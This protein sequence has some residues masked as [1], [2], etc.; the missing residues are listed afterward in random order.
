MTSTGSKLGFRIKNLE[1]GPPMG[2]GGIA[3]C[4]A[5]LL[6]N[7]WMVDCKDM[8]VR[9]Q[10]NLGHNRAYGIMALYSLNSRQD[11]L[12]PPFRTRLGSFLTNK[13]HPF[14]KQA[15]GGGLRKGFQTLKCRTDKS[16]RL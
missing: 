1:K 2:G 15:P 10:E 13:E 8:S 6:E 7:P 5:E 11:K 4:T 12:P 16:C 3:T 9:D 14:P